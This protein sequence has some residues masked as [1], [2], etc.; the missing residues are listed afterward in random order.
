[1]PPR[2]LK[3]RL[4]IVL[5]TCTLTFQSL[6]C[7]TFLHPERV[8]Q[9]R[10]RLDPAIVAL[11]AAGLLLFLVPGLIA[12]GIDFYNGTIY[13]PEH[14]YRG[15]SPDAIPADGWTAIPL[16]REIN[17]PEEMEAYLSEK[18]GQQIRL[19]QSYLRVTKHESLPAHD[20]VTQVAETEET[21][22]GFNWRKLFPLLPKKSDD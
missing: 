7:G 22:L 12:F 5:L 21:K 11:D 4:L 3:T 19:D 10:G 16:D 1:M 9:T 17:S 8:G 18:T 6:A 20:D 15:Q 2:S 13:L 14:E